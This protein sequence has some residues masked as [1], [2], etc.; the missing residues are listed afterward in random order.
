MK[1]YRVTKIYKHGLVIE[2]GVFNHKKM[3]EE[4]D[5]SMKEESIDYVQ[6]GPVGSV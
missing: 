3:L 6:V 2:L 1:K 4:I 5:L